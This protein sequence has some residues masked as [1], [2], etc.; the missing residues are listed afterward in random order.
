M[1]DWIRRTLIVAFWAAG[2]A[3]TDIFTVTMAV[4]F[5]QIKAIG[6][7]TVFACLMGG[8]MF[9]LLGREGFVKSLSTRL[10]RQEDKLRK[11]RLVKWALDKGK[12]LAVFTAGT[13]AGPMSGALALRVLGYSGKASYILIAINGMLFSLVWAG[14]IFGIPAFLIRSFTGFGV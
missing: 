4:L 1:Y 10:Q 3:T 14:V 7:V 5:G 13:T 11:R 6:I 9:Y 8:G 2:L 12:L